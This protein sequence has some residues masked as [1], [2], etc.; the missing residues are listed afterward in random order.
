MEALVSMNDS[1]IGIVKLFAVVV[2]QSFEFTS[3]TSNKSISK[4]FDSGLPFVFQVRGL[5]TMEK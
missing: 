3:R 5:Y 2:A 4:S 1:Y